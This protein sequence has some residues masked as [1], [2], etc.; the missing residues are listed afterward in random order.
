MFTLHFKLLVKII[1]WC[2]PVIMH[3]WPDEEKMASTLSSSSQQLVSAPC[4]KTL[5]MEGWVRMLL[6]KL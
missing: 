4:P 3:K 2:I 1:A 6:S 5:K